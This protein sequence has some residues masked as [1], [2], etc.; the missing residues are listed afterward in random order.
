MAFAQRL[1]HRHGHHLGAVR[2]VEFRGDRGLRRGGFAIDL[3]RRLLGF[4]GRRRFRRLLLARRA[5]AILQGGGVLALAQD[6][7]DRRV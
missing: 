7:G 4:R 2:N 3:R 6:H 5:T 1:A